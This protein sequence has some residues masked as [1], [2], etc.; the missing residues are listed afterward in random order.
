[1]SVDA[2]DTSIKVHLNPHDTVTDVYNKLNAAVEGVKK[3]AELDS[4]LDNLLKVFT[5][6][7]SLVMKFT[8]WFLK[9]LDYFGLLPAFLLALAVNVVVSMA[10]PEPDQEMQAIFDRVKESA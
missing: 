1:M 9:L 10:T 8:V 6:I 5:Y 4:S 3:T 7:P 2:P